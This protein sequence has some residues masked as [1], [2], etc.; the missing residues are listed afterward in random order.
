MAQ[1]GNDN[2]EFYYYDIV[3]DF[4]S[5]KVRTT[6]GELRQL[7]R[8]LSI[9]ASEGY[10][11]A[12]EELPS[13]KVQEVAARLL[14]ISFHCFGGITPFAYGNERRKKFPAFAYDYYKEQYIYSFMYYLPKF[15]RERG[16]WP[17]MAA[18]IRGVALNKTIT[19]LRKCDQMHEAMEKIVAAAKDLYPDMDQVTQDIV[20]NALERNIVR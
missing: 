11:Q 17:W 1:R 9:I 4:S 2:D 10:R 15:F 3:G 8:E 7:E 19:Y 16:S 12:G 14:S 5:P 6:R 13:R 20:L 18:N